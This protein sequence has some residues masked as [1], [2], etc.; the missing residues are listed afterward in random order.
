MRFLVVQ[1][2]TFNRLGSKD[3][4]FKAAAQILGYGVHNSPALTLG[5][6]AHSTHSLG[7]LIRFAFIRMTMSL[8]CLGVSWAGRRSIEFTWAYPNRFAAFT[9]VPPSKFIKS[10]FFMPRTHVLD[11][12]MLPQGL[13]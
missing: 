3:Y 1:V 6:A 5:A 9:A 12:S 11:I 7:Y 13:F 8:I 10:C 2:F 4:S